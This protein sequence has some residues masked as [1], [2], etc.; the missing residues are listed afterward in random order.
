MIIMYGERT[1]EQTSKGNDDCVLYYIVMVCVCVCVCVYVCDALFGLNRRTTAV[2]G[3][4]ARFRRGDD[5]TTPMREKETE[6]ETICTRIYTVYT[7]IYTRKVLKSHCALRK[8]RFGR[9]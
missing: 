1:T 5:V 7:I 3:A 6:R 2:R 8:T 4:R 9:F